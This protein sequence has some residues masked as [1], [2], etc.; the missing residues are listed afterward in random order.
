[1]MQNGET[2]TPPTAV[3]VCG[4]VFFAITVVGGL[5]A[6]VWAIVTT[7]L[8]I[9]GAISDIRVLS[10][11]IMV[12]G[13]VSEHIVNFPSSCDRVGVNNGTREWECC[14]GDVVFRYLQPN[15]ALRQPTIQSTFRAL[16][17]TC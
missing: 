7:L 8:S 11:A 2:N 15:T 10:N 5:L 4:V 3:I 1:M 17:W 9:P 16:L 13:I 6:I 14:G 12:T